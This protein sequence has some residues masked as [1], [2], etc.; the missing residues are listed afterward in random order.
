M[1]L[2]SFNVLMSL[3]FGIMIADESSCHPN[4]KVYSLDFPAWMSGFCDISPDLSVVG[5][6]I[7]PISS[8]TTARSFDIQNRVWHSM[9]YLTQ[10]DQL[11]E[12]WIAVNLA[13][14]ENGIPVVLGFDAITV[15]SLTTISQSK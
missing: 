15:R 4:Q 11:V 5:L 9:T 6:A 14:R 7:R 8:E 3:G 12:T 13:P 1:L 10:I 2:L